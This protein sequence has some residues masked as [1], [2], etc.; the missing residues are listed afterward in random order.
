MV[1]WSADI[2]ESYNHPWCEW[3]DPDVE[4]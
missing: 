2:Q 1:R 4:G 3:D